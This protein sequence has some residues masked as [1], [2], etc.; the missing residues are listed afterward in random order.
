MTTEYRVLTA[1]DIEQSAYVESVAFYNEPGPG[2]V[3]MAKK[4]LPPDWTVG[5]FVDGKLV[6]DVRMVPMVRRINGG[7]MAF[8]AV[9]PVACLS[10][11]RRQGHVGKLLRLSLET[12]R[13]R[14][15][16][17][18][19]LHTPHD[20]LYARYGWERAEGRVRY[21]FFP[22]DIH[23]RHRG[24][25]GNIEQVTK[26]DWERL[27]GIYQQH[28]GRRNGAFT[29]NAVWWQVA[30]LAQFSSAI[31]LK[32]NDIFV[33]VSAEGRDEGYVVYNHRELP[34]DRDWPRRAVHIRDFVALTPDAYTGLWQHMLTHD[35][36]EHVV[37]SMPSDDPF[38]NL[39]HDPFR[40]QVS[41]GYGAMLRIVD[42]EQAIALRPYVGDRPVSFT[43]RILDHT[44]PWNE[45]ALRI[46][47]AEGRMRAE[48]TEAEPDLE[49]TANTLAPVFTG[50]MTPEVAR[51]VGL[52]RVFRD[53]AVSE[54]AE[55]FRVLYPPYCHDSY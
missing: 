21:Q 35:L 43:V 53:E 25:P 13:E 47:A 34:S 5:A 33:W 14:G 2:R 55:A 24:N 37:A 10:A 15:Q 52:L 48:R 12:M 39:V 46:E 45:G 28:T 9:G 3:E 51:G 1:D 16:V 36:A 44:A 27:D 22:K 38:P 42:V 8:A 41:P 4:Y 7:T 29:R 32:D 31:E 54:M 20:A 30:V 11:F 19:G 23:L 6:A 18:S 49:L 40:V 26:D 50:H 17:M